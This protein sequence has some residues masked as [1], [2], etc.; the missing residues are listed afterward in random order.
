MLYKHRRAWKD[1]STLPTDGPVN[2]TNPASEFT[3]ENRP[4]WGSLLRGNDHMP[5]AS[6]FKGETVTFT[7]S[8]FFG[9]FWCF[10]P[11]PARVAE[12]TPI[13]SIRT[14]MK[15]VTTCGRVLMLSGISKKYPQ[16]VM[17]LGNESAKVLIKSGSR[18]GFHGVTVDSTIK[19][20]ALGV[21]EAYV[22]LNPRLWQIA[23]KRLA[24]ICFFQA[25]YAN[26]SFCRIYLPRK[27]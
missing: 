22:P 5:L 24:R 14:S 6:I 9:D 11:A 20:I 27:H 8:V 17:L 23:I 13:E 4:F 7:R 18:Q 26:P 3:P 21:S 12:T 1:R 16:Q 2:S 19:L 10:L 25:S 15:N